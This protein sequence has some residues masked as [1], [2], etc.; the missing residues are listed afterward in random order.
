MWC[1]ILKDK[2]NGKE[3]VVPSCWGVASRFGAWPEGMSDRQVI[4]Q[5]CTCP[6]NKKKEEKYEV[7]TKDEVIIMLDALEQK[8][9]QQKELLA[10]MEE[11]FEVIKSEVF[12]LNTVEV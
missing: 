4:K 7:H 6:R 5:Y 1:H 12:M 11:E 9:Q 2:R 3:Y 10:A 8:I